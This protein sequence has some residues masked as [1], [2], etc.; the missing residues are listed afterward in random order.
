MKAR[1]GLAAAAAATE[2]RGSDRGSGSDFIPYL[3]LKHDGDM[4]KIRFVTEIS[5]EARSV[6]NAMID[7]ALGE[8]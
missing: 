1:R 8:E 7:A 2:K 5:D 4:A 6:W 3:Q